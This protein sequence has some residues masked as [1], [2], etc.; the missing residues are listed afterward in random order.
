L[1]DSSPHITIE[2][3]SSA[4][5]LAQEADLFTQINRLYGKFLLHL[6]GRIL[7][8]SQRGKQDE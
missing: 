6:I 8:C 2:T 1:K 4:V 7:D 3:T 5:R